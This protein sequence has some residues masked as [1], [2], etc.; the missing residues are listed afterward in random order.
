Y[1]NSS[2]LPVGYTEDIFSALEVQD[3]LQTL[4]T[5]GTV[6]HAFL[7]EKL[8]DWKAAANL[9][10]KIAENYKLPYYT[11]SPTYSVCSEHGYLAGEQH[12]CPHCGKEAE[13]YSRITGY[14]RPVKNWND[15]KSQEFQDRKVY[16]IAN[17]KLTRNGVPVPTACDVPNG[18]NTPVVAD[19]ARAI[20]FSRVTCPNCRV[21]ESML[22]KAG[23]AY[24]K[25]IADDNVDLCRKYGVK[26]APTLVITDGTNFESYY[27]VPEIKKF[28][29]SEQAV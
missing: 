18:G 25:L 22:N 8:P 23:F 16:D 21:A 24:E 1:T 14:Y 27:S 3:E 4:Y 12:T 29:A 15:G 2:H 17:S 19:N 10:R 6:F 26:G 7:G 28:L 11:M 9:V 5:S 13:V 20:L